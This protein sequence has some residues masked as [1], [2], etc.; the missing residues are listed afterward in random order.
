MRSSVVVSGAVRERPEVL[1]V[2][3]P[4]ATPAAPPMRSADLGDR[5]DP[6]ATRLPAGLTEKDLL[7]GYALCAGGAS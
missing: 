4:V 7:S 3:T 6:I 2:A 1:Q 5:M